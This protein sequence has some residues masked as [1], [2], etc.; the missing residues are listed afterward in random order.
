MSRDL[1]CIPK[2]TC[3]QDS[4]ARNKHTLT[5]F[6]CAQLS[7]NDISLAPDS[8]AGLERTLKNL[9]MKSCRLKQ[10]PAAVKAL[11]SLAF[12]DLAQNSIRQLEPGNSPPPNSVTSPKR[13]SEEPCDPHPKRTTERVHENPQE[14]TLPKARVSRVFN[15]ISRLCDFKVLANVLH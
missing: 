13:E 7:E 14:Q 6:S 1:V 15:S 5:Q 11:T 9:N 12:L 2:C 3:V 4:D 10:L 8:F